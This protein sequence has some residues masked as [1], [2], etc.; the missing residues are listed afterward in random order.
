MTSRNTWTLQDVIEEW[1]LQYLQPCVFHPLPAFV[2][3]QLPRFDHCGLKHPVAI[4]DLAKVLLPTALHAGTEVEWAPYS[5][6]GY[7]LHHG[8]T[9]F[10]GDYQYHRTAVGYLHDDAVCAQ[11]V[12]GPPS[13]DLVYCVLVRRD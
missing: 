4:D 6:V 10:S 11:A 12:A 1:H 9:A 8:D 2:L 3:L 5:R 13:G 7:V